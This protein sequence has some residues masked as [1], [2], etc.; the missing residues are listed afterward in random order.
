[1]IKIFLAR[2]CDVSLNTIRTMFIVKGN[3]LVSVSIAFFEILIW[4]FAVREALTNVSNTYY[5]AISYALGYSCGTLLG[6]IIN[7]IFI[8]G[9]YT[10]NVI[11]NTISNKDI[12][13]IKSKGYG[14]SVFDSIDN[15]KYL[16]ICINK[17][18]YKECI[19]LIKDLDS[20]SFIMV[21]DSRV[22]Y[23]GYL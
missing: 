12:L 9:I 14:V 10:I 11:S 13:T 19:K 22:S 3:K 20:R 2:I 16:I 5:V 18:K 15:K 6:M 23:N 17:R 7:D 1:M 4:F 21:N 8:N